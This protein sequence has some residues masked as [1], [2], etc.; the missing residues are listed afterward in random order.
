MAMPFFPFYVQDWLSSNSVSVMTLAE[1][2]AYTELLVRMWQEAPKEGC[3]LPADDRTLSR[4]LHVSPQ[5]WQELREVLIDGPMAVFHV[6]DGHL[7]NERLTKEWEKAL[8]ISQKRSEAASSKRK[9]QPEDRGPEQEPSN[10][11]ANAQQVQDKSDASAQPLQPHLTSHISQGTRDTGTGNTEP[12]AVPYGDSSSAGAD[13]PT[14][15]GA[16][17]LTGSRDDVRAVMEHWNAVMVPKVFARPSLLTD[18]RRRQIRAR[19]KTFTVAQL[20]TAIDNLAASPFHGGENDRGWRA[21]PQFLFRNDSQV[22]TWQEPPAP[23][24]ARASP[25]PAGYA[26]IRDYEDMRQA[27]G[28]LT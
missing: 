14:Q 17:A 24:V 26:G 16:D 7:V 11:E 12:E 23:G 13:D 1:K 25:E 9:D 8:G 6:E 2:G 22:D 10:D 20:C 5:E 3:F 18:E 28:G 19:L 4:M 15:H 27:G 21:N